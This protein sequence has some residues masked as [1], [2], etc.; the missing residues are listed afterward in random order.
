MVVILGNINV[1]W[2]PY[3]GLSNERLNGAQIVMNFSQNFNEIPGC[4]I[5]LGRQMLITAETLMGNKRLVC[6]TY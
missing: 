6:E 1:L 5:F 4:K 2:I 3:I